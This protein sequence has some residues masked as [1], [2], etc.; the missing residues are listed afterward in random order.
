MIIHN[1]AVEV[2]Q[3]DS[4]IRIAIDHVLYGQDRSLATLPDDSVGEYVRRTFQMSPAMCQAVA[5]YV[6]S[7][8]AD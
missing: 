5:E 6:K 4:Q 1:Q 7:V 3:A 2:R 8:R